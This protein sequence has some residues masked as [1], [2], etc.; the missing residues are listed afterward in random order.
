[1]TALIWAAWGSVG[2]VGLLALTVI[3][4][5][6]SISDRFGRVQERQEVHGERLEALEHEIRARSEKDVVM[7]AT[8]A[9]MAAD[10]AHMKGRLESLSRV[11]VA[12]RHLLT[13]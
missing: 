5:A 12:P 8:L 9:T 10:I 11:E 6:M 3:I 1:M 7:A 2:A 13:D 4:Q